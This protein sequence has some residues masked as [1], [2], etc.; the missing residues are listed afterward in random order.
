MEPK[1]YYN[2]EN[3]LEKIKKFYRNIKEWFAISETLPNIREIV[4][5]KNSY[6]IAFI[7][8]V[9]A[10]ASGGLQVIIDTHSEIFALQLSK[11]LNNKGLKKDFE[12]KTNN[13]LPSVALNY[14]KRN[15]SDGSSEISHLFLDEEGFFIDENGNDAEWPEKNGFFGYRHDL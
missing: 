4:K 11:I 8:T 12:S 10:L 2:I 9:A 7:T 1:N 3:A 15:S 6:K 13:I 5:E 14:F